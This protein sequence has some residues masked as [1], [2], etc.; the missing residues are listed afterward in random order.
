MC[1]ISY[2]IVISYIFSQTKIK[3]CLKISLLDCI[4]IDWIISLC[5]LLNEFSKLAFKFFS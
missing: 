4:K 5:Y 3:F 2:G 1:F